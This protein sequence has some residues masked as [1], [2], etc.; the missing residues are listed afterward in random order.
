MRNAGND[1]DVYF[2]QHVPPQLR[3]AT[4][5]HLWRDELEDALLS[6]GQEH[7]A[8]LGEI[9]VPTLIMWGEHY[10]EGVL[11]H[12]PWGALGAL[13]G[14][15]AGSGGVHERGTSRSVVLRSRSDSSYL[16]R[17]IKQFHRD[18]LKI[19]WRA[20]KRPCV[21]ALKATKWRLWLHFDHS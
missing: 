4:T 12:G 17:L 19:R 7:A 3:F 1:T 18:C 13:R 21:V 14:G 6:V 9:N 8:W 20:L 15:C 11:R 10:A 5:P 16:I 2:E